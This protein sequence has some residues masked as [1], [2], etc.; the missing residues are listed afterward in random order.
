MA[1]K[2]L[3]YEWIIYTLAEKKEEREKFEIFELK[4]VIKG[5]LC[6]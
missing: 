5:V 6:Q 1:G 2:I 4:H 3:E